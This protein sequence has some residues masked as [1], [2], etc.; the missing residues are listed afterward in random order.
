MRYAYIIRSTKYIEMVPCS[1]G[2]ALQKIK[3]RLTFL[4]G[5]DVITHPEY[6]SILKQAKS[7]IAQIRLRDKAEKS[8]AKLART[9]KK[10]Q[11]PNITN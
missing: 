7:T 4:A 6:V 2:T 8:A 1:L 11:V 9:R 10:K 3:S 5:Q